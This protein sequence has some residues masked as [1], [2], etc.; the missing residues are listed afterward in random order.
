VG[1]KLCRILCI[2]KLIFPYGF[3]V[4]GGIILEAESKLLTEDKRNSKFMFRFFCETA[5]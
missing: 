2:G 3:K 5:G 1:S 4:A